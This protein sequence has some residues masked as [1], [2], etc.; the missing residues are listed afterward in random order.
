MVVGLGGGT[1]V[2]KYKMLLDKVCYKFVLCKECF[3]CG[4][5]GSE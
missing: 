2:W 3:V 5:H 4:L 1:G